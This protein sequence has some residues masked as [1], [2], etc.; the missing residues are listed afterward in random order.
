[1]DLHDWIRARDDATVVSFLDTKKNPRRFRTLVTGTFSFN[2]GQA[3]PIELQSRART[4]GR[5]KVKRGSMV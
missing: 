5:R 3:N 1:M 4:E 2:G